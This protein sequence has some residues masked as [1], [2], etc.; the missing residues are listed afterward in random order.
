MNKNDVLEILNDWNFWRGD[1]RAGVERPFYL[2]RLQSCLATNQV[3]AITGPRRSGKSYLMRQLAK[4]R[5][6]SG[7]PANQVLMINFE[8]PR[9]G[10]L[11]AKSLDRIYQ[12]YLEF[13]SPS[14][15]PYVFLDEI[16]EVAEWEKWVRMMHELEKAKIVVSGSNAKLLGHE[17]ATLLTGRH[18][19]VTVYPFSFREMKTI[20]PSQTPTDFRRIVNECLEFGSFP[21]VVSSD[22]SERRPILLQYFDDI[23]NKDLIRRYR[24]RKP[25][26]LK[27]LARFYFTNHASLTTYSATEKFLKISAD[28]I[29][30]F[31]GYFEDAYLFSFLKRFSFKV[32]EQEKSPRKVYAVDT[33]LANAVGFRSSPNQGRLAEG[34]VFQELE[35]RFSQNSDSELF[36]WK[37]AQHREV[38]F[39][40]KRGQRVVQLLQTSWLSASAGAVADTIDQDQQKAKTREVSSLLKAMEDLK[41][42][43]GTIV[44]QDYEAEEKT[45]SGTIHYIPLWK[46]LADEA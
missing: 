41:L 30:K 2:D 10:E 43:E 11:N 23:L 14:S 46:W 4:K 6:A 40:V 31:S 42:Q 13:L 45:K 1:L 32:K 38:D 17:L 18:L 37:D 8:D 36:Y 34:M 21:E 5:M 22:V 16:Q 3:I 19:S 26:A 44:T 9:F 33:G 39:V 24:I 12:I 7:V 28:T 20:R 35:R 25:D 15:L 27:S 29:E